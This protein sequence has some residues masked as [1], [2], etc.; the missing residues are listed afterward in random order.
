M[1]MMRYILSNSRFTED[2]SVYIKDYIDLAFS[3]ESYS[4]P[5]SS[6]GFRHH[7]KGVGRMELLS[8]IE[9]EAEKTISQLNSILG[10]SLNINSIEW[11][12]ELNNI[13]TINI[14]GLG[15]GFK[16]NEH[17]KN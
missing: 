14:K 9:Y 3:T 17:I 12:D 7:Y 1:K 13:I 8:K 15:N 6:L 5:T 2:Y 11:Q 16:I 10:T 4:I